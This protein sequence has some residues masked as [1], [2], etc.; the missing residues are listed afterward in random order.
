MLLFKKY[1]VKLFLLFKKK[2]CKHFIIIIKLQFSLILGNL[3]I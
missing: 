3:G 1:K 2:H